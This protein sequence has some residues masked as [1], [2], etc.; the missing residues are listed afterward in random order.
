MQELN[1]KLVL[2]PVYIAEYIELMNRIYMFES[3]RT[4]NYVIEGNEIKGLD[5]AHSD[6]IKQVTAEAGEQVKVG[7]NL[8]YVYQKDE[9]KWNEE[10]TQ[11]GDYVG[12][13][14]QLLENL[15]AEIEKINDLSDKIMD[16]TLEE[17][18]RNGYLDKIHNSGNVIITKTIEYYQNSGTTEKVNITVSLMNEAEL[19]IYEDEEVYEI[20]IATN[21]ANEEIEACT[22]LDVIT[23]ETDTNNNVTAEKFIESFLPFIEGD[24]NK[25]MKKAENEKYNSF[26]MVEWGA[27]V[28][29]VKGADDKL[30]LQDKNRNELIEYSQMLATIQGERDLMQKRGKKDQIMV[31]FQQTTKG[32]FFEILTSEKFNY[33]AQ[34]QV[35]GYY[36]SKGF[37][38]TDGK[39]DSQI[40]ENKRR[41]RKDGK[42]AGLEE[43]NRYRITRMPEYYIGEPLDWRNDNY[44]C[45]QIYTLNADNLSIYHDEEY[46]DRERTVWSKDGDKKKEQEM[47]GFFIVECSRVTSP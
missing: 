24:I 8:K 17:S 36:I 6:S 3:M 4:P 20:F 2:E 9:Y 13:H 10:K 16:S 12:A 46:S 27:F 31:K 41:M 33:R 37:N 32:T 29:P 22:S 42:P 39:R 19:E 40:V 43:V 21:Q 44:Y 15:K 38:D 47:I 1:N 45:N 34:E 11:Q 23:G 18:A 7:D 25:I 30:Y 26:D 14:S 5:C 35:Y 28:N